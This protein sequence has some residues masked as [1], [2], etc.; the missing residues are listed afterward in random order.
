M[1]LIHPKDK[2]TGRKKKKETIEMTREG[3]RNELFTIESIKPRN[4]VLS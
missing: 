1:G 2:R 3:S 4:L